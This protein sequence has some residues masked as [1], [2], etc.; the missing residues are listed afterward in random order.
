M[1]LST[2]KSPSLLRTS[3][4]SPKKL[5]NE[6]FPST[7]K[8]KDPS[9]IKENLLEPSTLHAKPKQSVETTIHELK[10]QVQTVLAR[11]KELRCSSSNNASDTPQSPEDHAKNPD[12]LPPPSFLNHFYVNYP[13]FKEILGNFMPVECIDLEMESTNMQI[14]SKE[15]CVRLTPTDRAKIHTT[16]IKGINNKLR[17]ADYTRNGRGHHHCQRHKLFPALRQTP[18]TYHQHL[19]SLHFLHPSVQ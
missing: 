13:S 14:I 18:E 17:G 7:F 6:R 15:E 5:I 11:I 1:L 3:M 19:C 9:F 2:M 10:D 8:I 12:K 16:F 4:W